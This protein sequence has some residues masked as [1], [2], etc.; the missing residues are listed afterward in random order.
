LFFEFDKP[1]LAGVEEQWL[2]GDSLLITPVLREGETEVKGYFPNA[3]G[4][5][6]DW[7]THHVSRATPSTALRAWTDLY[8]PFK[9]TMITKLPS[10]PLLEALTSISDPDPSSSS[11]PSLHITS[12]IPALQSMGWS[13][14]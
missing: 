14:R 10:L 9:S 13:S 2:I 7:Y 3:G 12:L 1:E 11:T 6:R 4:A 8:S 5:W